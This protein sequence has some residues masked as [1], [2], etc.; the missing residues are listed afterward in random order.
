MKAKVHYRDS[1][2]WPDGNRRAI[3]TCMAERR[4]IPDGN[5]KMTDCTG[6]VTCK[7]CWSWIRGMIV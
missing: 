2:L 7:R 6:E 4:P 3:P 1:V 5:Y